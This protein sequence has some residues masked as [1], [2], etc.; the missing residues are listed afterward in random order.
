MAKKPRE[1]KAPKQTCGLVMPI[2]DFEGYPAGHWKDVRT[3]IED[4]L[5]KDFTVSLV[6]ERADVGVIHARIVENLFENPIIVVDVSG[7]NSNVM[8]ELGI[9]LATDQPTVLIKDDKTPFSFDTQLIE[10]IPYR[11]DLHHGSIEE[12]KIELSAKVKATLEEKKK[13]GESYS[14]FL[15]HFPKYRPKKLETVEES[16]QDRVE[17]KLDQLLKQD[18]IRSSSSSGPVIASGLL[19]LRE[20][21]KGA[22]TPTLSS[23]FTKTNPL[24]EEM[25]EALRLIS[26]NHFAELKAEIADVVKRI[27]KRD[28]EN[29]PVV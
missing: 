2:S 27:Q 5:S 26:E 17:R 29:D 15:K 16:Q 14:P 18:A 21:M 1:P 4:A 13:H 6:S 7:R 8:T 24:S 9:R 19:S 11:S 12:F 3:I 23:R 22:H 25:K 20:K 28:S 10:H